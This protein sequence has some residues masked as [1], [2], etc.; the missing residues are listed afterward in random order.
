MSYLLNKLMQSDCG[1]NCFKFDPRCDS[2]WGVINFL[3][4]NVESRGTDLMFYFD[5]ERFLVVM[6]NQFV[7]RSEDG[8]STALCFAGISGCVSDHGSVNS[9]Q[10]FYQPGKFKYKED[11]D[12]IS[13]TSAIICFIHVH[14]VY[15]HSCTHCI[16]SH[17]CT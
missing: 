15:S 1:Q 9:N 11:E 13:R 8:I 4:V 5:F 3:C 17:S 14:V 6:S 2:L 12:E 16:Y 10:R 7:I